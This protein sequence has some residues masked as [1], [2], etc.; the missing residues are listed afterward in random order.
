MASQKLKK[1]KTFRIRLT[2]WQFL[3]LQSYADNHEK[4][5]SQ[6]ISDYI[7]RLPVQGEMKRVLTEI[8]SSK[9]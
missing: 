4:A 9:T 2:E 1:T 6:V 8:E 3:K 7:H 5:M